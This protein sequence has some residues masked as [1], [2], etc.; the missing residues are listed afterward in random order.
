MGDCLEKLR[1]DKMAVQ[2]WFTWYAGSGTND[3]IDGLKKVS[4]ERFFDWNTQ[5]HVRLLF[6]AFAGS[7]DFLEG[8]YSQFHT[9]EGYQFLADSILREDR[10]TPHI[11]AGFMVDSLC[12]WRNY[13]ER[14]QKL[15]LQQLER[16]AAAPNLSNDTGDKVRR[17]LPTP[18]E[19]RNLFNPPDLKL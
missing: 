19:R 10:I 16:V 5:G 12:T 2:N 7:K 4:G 1:E 18:E 14:T 8:N 11:A 3:V 6:G 17:S 13:D 15:M 9:P